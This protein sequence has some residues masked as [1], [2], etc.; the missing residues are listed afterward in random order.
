M[1]VFQQSIIASQGINGQMKKKALFSPPPSRS[2]SLLV[3]VRVFGERAVPEISS[4]QKEESIADKIPYNRSL[5]G[6]AGDKT[7]AVDVQ[8][9]HGIEDQ[10]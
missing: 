5:L 2:K 9:A 10:S 8:P 4:K 3:R 1:Q 6:R 7:A